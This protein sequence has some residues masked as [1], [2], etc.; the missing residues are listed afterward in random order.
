M[1]TQK[2]YAIQPYNMNGL[3]WRL[4]PTESL[5]DNIIVA[6]GFMPSWWETECGITFGKD[7]HLEATTHRNTLARMEAILRERFGDLPHFFCGDDYANAWPIE[8]RYGDGLILALLGGHVTFDDGSGHPHPDVMNLSDE[9]A[10]ALTVP[11]VENSSLLRSLVENGADPSGRRT[12][13]LGFEGIV[14]NVYN[15]RGQQMFVDL[16]ETPQLF[17]HLCEVVWQTTCR[18]VRRFR[19]WQDPTGA[20]P[21]HFV[22]ADCLINMLSADTYKEH[23]LAFEHRFNESFDLYGVHTCNWTVD[24]YLDALAQIDGLAYLDMGS[25]SDLDKV[26]K[27]FPD[28]QPAVFLDP[29]EVRRSELSELKRKTLQLCKRLSRGFILLSD[30]PAGTDDAK[31]RMIHEVAADF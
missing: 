25:E 27:L 4:V 20:K 7:F 10:A 19:Q 26:H 3:N 8:R 28:L 6:T 12:G 11:D 24:P 1:G 2:D 31:I 15:L 16:L 29:E 5:Q 21:L 9:Q 30:L 13:E 14:N 23:L 17:S 18:V 22:N